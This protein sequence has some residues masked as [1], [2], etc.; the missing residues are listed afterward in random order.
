MTPTLI[1]FRK[2]FREMLRDK[3]VRSSAF[4]APLIMIFMMMILF[5]FLGDTLSK[6]SNQKVYVVKA[7]NVVI[8]EL[9]AEKLNVIFLDTVADGEKMIQ[10]GKASVVLAFDPK[11][12]ENIAE[13]KP[14]GI[15]ALYDPK[16][17]KSEIVLASLREAIGKMNK[18]TLK[19]LLRRKG[20]DPA[21]ADPVNLTAKVVK[22]GEGSTSEIIVSLLPY[23]IVIWAF[24]GGFGIASDLVAGEKEKNTLETLLISPVDRNQIALGKFFALA[25][26]CLI[27]SLSS[28]LGIVL[29]KVV[30]LPMTQTLFSKGLGITPV[31]ATIIVAVLLPAVALFAS[32]LL[33]ISAYA[34]NP[35]E[36]QTHLTVASFVVLA[37]AIFSQFIGFTDLSTARWINLVPV[38][39]TATQ[40]RQALLGKFDPVAIGTTI[41]VSLLLAAISM[42]VAVHLFNREEVLVRV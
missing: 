37:P 30:N 36:A 29:V 17:P 16:Q 22:V 33:A 32:V 21:M 12:T 41:G 24:Y 38:L 35:R 26:V 31:S 13:S 42:R 19:S 18:D 28:L 6:P 8:H 10:D 4:F 1:I 25:A 23:L 15:T 40:I 7:D 3:R 2:E 27:S 39:D 9:E 11:F 5:G 20:V 14:A 34:R